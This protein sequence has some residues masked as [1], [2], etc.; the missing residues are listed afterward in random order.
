MR[1]RSAI[2]LILTLSL[3]LWPVASWT[4]RHAAL[5]GS[6]AWKVPGV[7]WFGG[8]SGMDLSSDGG[9]MVAVTDRGT[10]LRGRI[11]RDGDRITGVSGL[12]AQPLA[13]APQLSGPLIDS[14]G[15]A[16]RPDGTFCVSFEQD[17]KIG[18]YTAPGRAPIP[19]PPPPEVLRLHSNSTL[20]ALAVDRQGRLITIP[21]ARQK[22]AA[23]HRVY[24]FE[25]GR[26]RVLF[27]F[28]HQGGFLPVGADVGPDGRLYVLE[29]G[30]GALG[31]RAQIRSWALTGAG[32]ADERRHLRTPY[33]RHGNLEALSVWRDGQGR[34]RLTMVA[35]DNF[36]ALLRSE[37]VEYALPTLASGARND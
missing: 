32:A 11:E 2:A 7:P 25:G 15:V 29:R 12:T 20:E 14:E 1:F 19:L 17:S 33:L 26:W 4:D 13:G 24:R 30:F 36:L 9:E 35:D 34:I 31:F 27:D 23:H 5:V 21:E 18:C 28:A 22:G 8:L 10:L 3:T 16:R 6:Y 37:I